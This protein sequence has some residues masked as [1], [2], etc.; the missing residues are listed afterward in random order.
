V[1]HPAAAPRLL[2]HQEGIIALI[3][4]T[5]LLFRSGGPLPA[6][7]PKGS[8]VDAVAWGAA[9]GL[10]ISGC[11]WLAR[12]AAPIRNLE[13]CLAEIL[14]NLNLAD[15][16][17]LAVISGL[18]E[19]ALLRALLQPIIGLVPVAVL[20]A[21]LHIYPDRRAWAWPVVALGIGIALGV[22]YQR[23]GYPAAA[24]AHGAINL[25]SLTRLSRRRQTQSDEHSV[26][27]DN[28]AD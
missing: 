20:F 21:L 13:D 16:I 19:E 4:L 5:G 15:G 7:A 23:L 6:L 11:L 24:A 2:V 12:T 26:G 10:S 17:A 27:D 14:K 8:M 25:V 18:A 22:L 9:V 28:P 3:A 1:S